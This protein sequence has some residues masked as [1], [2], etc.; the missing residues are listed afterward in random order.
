MDTTK[1]LSKIIY[2]ILSHK[3]LLNG[4]NVQ[5]NELFFEYLS[6]VFQLAFDI[7]LDMAKLKSFVSEKSTT[8]E[9]EKINKFL[10]QTLERKETYI[11]LNYYMFIFLQNVLKNLDNKNL[12]GINEMMLS[13]GLSESDVDDVKKEYWSFIHQGNKPQAHPATI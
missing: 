11:L 7:N 12:L 1:K 9:V 3:E 5:I 6:Q 13:Q 2:L 4:E 10:V 8:P